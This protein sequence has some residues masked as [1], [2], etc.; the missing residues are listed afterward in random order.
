MHSLHAPGV[1]RV[2]LFRTEGS[3][4]TAISEL[5]AVLELLDRH[6]VDDIH[7]ASSDGPDRTEAGRRLTGAQLM[8]LDSG[9][10]ADPV[11][12]MMPCLRPGSAVPVSVV[13]LARICQLTSYRTGK[14]VLP[15][16][17]ATAPI[18]NGYALRLFCGWPGGL[19][20]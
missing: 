13:M 15:V 10:P 16:A 8:L 14:A 19:M 5:S 20:D 9:L 1:D 6:Q 3:V 7:S 2:H 12:L 11:W 17:S 4:W 18:F